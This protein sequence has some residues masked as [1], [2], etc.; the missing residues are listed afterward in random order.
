MHLSA[1]IALSELSSMNKFASVISRVEVG[2]QT[3]PPPIRKRAS[4]T[5]MTQTM[6]KKSAET[7]TKLNNK[8]RKVM[9]SVVSDVALQSAMMETKTSVGI[10]VEFD[11]FEL[12]GSVLSKDRPLWAASS[13]QTS[14]TRHDVEAESPFRGNPSEFLLLGSEKSRPPKLGEIEQLSTET[15]TDVGQ[16]MMGSRTFSANVS[17]DWGDMEPAAEFSM[18]Q[19]EA[20]T[21]F[22]LDDILCSNYTQTGSILEN[23]LLSMASNHV[24]AN[25]IPNSTSMNSIE[26]QTMDSIFDVDIQA[27]TTAHQP[28]L[29]PSVGMQT[30]MET[31]T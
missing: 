31:Q 4:A 6:L 14:P 19:I 26:T 1:A 11:D 5:T 7:Q 18:R 3:D 24:A 27:G 10:G 12:V 2:V 15:Q 21:Q 22:D 28:E 17:Q 25:S 9:G 16:H 8:K 30:H 23:P 29:H 20:E 13:T